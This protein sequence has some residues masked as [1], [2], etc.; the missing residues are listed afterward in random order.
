MQVAAKRI[1]VDWVLPTVRH[2]VSRHLVSRDSLGC[3]Q[4]TLYEAVCLVIAA[5]V[6]VVEKEQFT[7]R[8]LLLAFPNLMER[9]PEL[10]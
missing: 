4:M 10:L 7:I 8:R 5:K 2:S 3:T 1:V 9:F 6:T